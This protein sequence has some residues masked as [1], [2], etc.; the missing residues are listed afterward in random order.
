MIENREPETI[1]PRGALPQLVS[2]AVASFILHHVQLDVQAF[3]TAIFKIAGSQ[4]GISLHFSFFCKTNA[5]FSSFI[6][7]KAMEFCCDI[8]RKLRWWEPVHCSWLPLWVFRALSRSSS[9]AKWLGSP[10]ASDKT[11]D[12]VV[13]M[14]VYDEKQLNTPRS[15]HVFRCF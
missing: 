7:Q 4:V 9:F 1:A 12:I 11:K 5:C 2:A 8:L 6:S 10:T 15:D 3:C 13:G 14:C